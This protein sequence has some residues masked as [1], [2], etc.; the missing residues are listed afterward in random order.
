MYNDTT[1]VASSQFSML[2]SFHSNYD[3]L[4][5]CWHGTGFNAIRHRE[6]FGRR[7]LNIELS[8]FPDGHSARWMTFLGALRSLSNLYGVR[9]E[10]LPTTSI[11]LMCVWEIPEMHD[12][13]GKLLTEMT[14]CLDVANNDVIEAVFRVALVSL[15]SVPA[16]NNTSIA[17]RIVTCYA[18]VDAWV[19]ALLCHLRSSSYVVFLL[20]MMACVGFVGMKN[21]I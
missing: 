14:A 16:S 7:S 10:G 2:H 3:G 8:S 19:D 12:V 17:I 9:M 13:F 20:Q 4:R 5:T 15:T 11:A 1:C 6:A 21:N 18:W